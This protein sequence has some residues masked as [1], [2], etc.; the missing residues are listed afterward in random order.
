MNAGASVKADDEAHCKRDHTALSGSTGTGYDGEGEP[1]RK[2]RKTKDNRKL[3]RYLH[4]P[5]T[6]S[7]EEGS[8]PPANAWYLLRNARRSCTCIFG[9]FSCSRWNNIWL[10]IHLLIM[11]TQPFTI[12]PPGPIP[13]THRQ[14]QTIVNAKS[15]S[16]PPKYWYNPQQS[17]GNSSLKT[18][19][20]HND[21]QHNTH[22][23]CYAGLSV[24]RHFLNRF[25]CLE[26]RS[27]VCLLMWQKKILFLWLLC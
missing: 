11:F 22:Y 23:H 10:Y 16:K 13:N 1:E 24:I 9:H 25:L 18:F 21:R 6:P 3:R 12:L 4:M 17:R 27:L 19:L 20:G 2:K 26:F 5:M 14:R 8:W 7:N 15:D